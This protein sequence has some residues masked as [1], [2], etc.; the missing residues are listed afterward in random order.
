VVEAND[1]IV[2]ELVVLAELAEL[3]AIHRYTDYQQAE[4][5]AQVQAAAAAVPAALVLS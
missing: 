2:Q 5:T 3:A 4:S 1:M